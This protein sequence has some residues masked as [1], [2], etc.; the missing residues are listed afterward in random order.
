[1]QVVWEKKE[2]LVFKLTFSP[3]FTVF[4]TPWRRNHIL[5]TLKLSSVIAFNLDEKFCW[6]IAQLFIKNP[7]IGKQHFL[8]FPMF[9]TLSKREIIILAMFNLSSANAF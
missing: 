4:S 5:A 1:M 2:I 9:S 3:F 6:I 7:N 8:L